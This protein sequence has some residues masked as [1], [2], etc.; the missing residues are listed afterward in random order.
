MCAVLGSL[1]EIELQEVRVKEAQLELEITK[2]IHQMISPTLFV[3]TPFGTISASYEP[4]ELPDPY[5]HIG[6]RDHNGEDEDIIDIE[7]NKKE[8]AIKVHS[9]DTLLDEWSTNRF[10]KNPLVDAFSIEQN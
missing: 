8:N 7:Y 3:E 9:K 1:S 4:D 2:K 10:D 5:I 6:F